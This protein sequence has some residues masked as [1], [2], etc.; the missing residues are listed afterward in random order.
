[1]ATG[2]RCM[3]AT[4]VVADYHGHTT[5]LSWCHGSILEV[6][7]HCRQCTP[8]QYSY[9]GSGVS[10]RPGS[11]QL[12]TSFLA[13]STTPNGGVTGWSSRSA[14]VMGAAPSAKRLPMVREDSRDPSEGATC[15]WM[16]ADKSPSFHHADDSPPLKLRQLFILSY[17]TA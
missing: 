6:T 12:R 2:C 15:A 8:Y 10:L 5:G 1:M 16:V 7:V 9:Y 17:K 13:R 11:I 4:H 14:H 3:S